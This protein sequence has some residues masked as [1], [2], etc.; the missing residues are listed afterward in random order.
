M[1]FLQKIDLYT[2]LILLCVVLLPVC[3]W[4][5]YKTQQ[6]IEACKAAVAR[7][8]RKN[9]TL[10]QIG[11]LQKKIEIVQNNRSGG[12]KE[13]ATFFDRQILVAAANGGLSSNDF[14]LK[15][16]R[17]ESVT[18]PGSKQPASD[19][20]MEVDW[21]KCETPMRLELVEALL[22]NLESGAGAAAGGLQSIWRLR[23]LEIVNTTDEKLLT[24]FDT[25]PPELEDRW[26]IKRMEF[27]RREPR[28]K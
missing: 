21:S 22:W 27:A 11:A 16:P 24:R 20:V 18:I 8:D 2:A 19:F 17:E 15:G 26:K 10:E 28:K 4:W 7:A 6:D 12:T 3:G 13:P 14:Q 23:E 9:G 5:V 25:P 1:K